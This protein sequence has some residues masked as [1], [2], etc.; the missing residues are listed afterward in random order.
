MWLILPDEG[1]TVDKQ[2]ED[3]S[4]MELIKP[5]T[6][7]QNSKR[8]IVHLSVPKFDIAAQMNLTQELKALGITDVFDPLQADF[9]SL[10]GNADW[11]Y[12]SQAVH[13]ARAAIDEE[14]VEAAAYTVMSVSTSA[15]SPEEEAD[16]VLN[17]PI[18]FIITNYDGIP[19]FAGVVNNP[20]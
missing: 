17:R 20:T 7:W 1:T 16:L 3:A 14:G 9:S 4:L 19:I 2:L 12:L 15:V 6:Q 11:I 13:Y 5:E 8:L 10:T 18:V